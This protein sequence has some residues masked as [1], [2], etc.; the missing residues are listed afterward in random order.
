MIL[1]RFKSGRPIRH[2]SSMSGNNRK[3]MSSEVSSKVTLSVA[4]PALFIPE[5]L[6]AMMFTLSLPLMRAPKRVASTGEQMLLAE[7]VSGHAE[8]VVLTLLCHCFSA[9]VFP[10]NTVM[11]SSSGQNSACGV[12]LE[13]PGTPTSLCMPL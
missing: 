7:P 5:P 13:R 9:N 12:E 10:N 4:V 6:A 11:L 8:M 2:L 1:N 3:S